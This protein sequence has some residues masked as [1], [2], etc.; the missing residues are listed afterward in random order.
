MSKHTH[1]TLTC[2]KNHIWHEP[3]P[4]VK[5]KPGEHRACP[6]CG[7][8]SWIAFDAPTVEL[9]AEHKG[10]RVNANLNAAAPIEL[11]SASRPSPEEIARTKVI[12]IP[13]S[14]IPT[15][16]LLN[17]DVADDVHIV[18]PPLTIEDLESLDDEQS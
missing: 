1:F 10:K 17:E 6:V 2:T 18:G 15:R 13:E 11:H 4:A 9:A 7:G 12:P 3:I 16:Q 5:P 14:L 8:S